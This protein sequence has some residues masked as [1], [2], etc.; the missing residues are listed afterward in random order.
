VLV[1]IIANNGVSSWLAKHT[2][3]HVIV[4]DHFVII[5]IVTGLTAIARNCN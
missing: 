4:I 2:H 5:V 1:G 3:G